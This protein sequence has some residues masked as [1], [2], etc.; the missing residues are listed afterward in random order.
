MLKIIEIITIK[1]AKAARSKYRGEKSF[2]TT[3]NLQS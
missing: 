1:Q 3:S 2:S